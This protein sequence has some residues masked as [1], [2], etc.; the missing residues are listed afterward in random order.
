MKQ[1]LVECPGWVLFSILLHSYFKTA[2]LFSGI[3]ALNPDISKDLNLGL[4][5]LDGT[6]KWHDDE[7]MSID[8]KISFCYMLQC[9]LVFFSWLQQWKPQSSLA[10]VK[11]CSIC[12][13]KTSSTKTSNLITSWWDR[14]K[15]SP[16]GQESKMSFYL[17]L[18]FFYLAKFATRFYLNQICLGCCS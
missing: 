4:C 12:T 10:C 16:V 5:T 13:V 2:D 14:H 8:D 17:L 6:F 18:L 11:V 15:C 3:C 1:I 9:L 7:M